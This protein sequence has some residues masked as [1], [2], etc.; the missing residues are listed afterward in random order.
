M[1]RLII[2]RIA[3]SAL[4]YLFVISSLTG[5]ALG[6]AIQKVTL[7]AA[8]T[9]KRVTASHDTFAQI[10]G[11]PKLREQAQNVNRPWLAGRSLPLA[12]EVTLPVALRSHVRTTL[13]FSDG[14]VALTSVAQRITKATGIP[15]YVHPEALLPNDLFTQRLGDDIGARAGLVPARQTVSLSG[16]SE[17]LARILDRVA[18]ALGVY[19]RYKH[20]RIEFYRTE[21]RVFNV[22]ALTLAVQAQAA[23][24]AGRQSGDSGFASSSRTELNSDAVGVME[25]VKARIEPFLTKAGIAVAQEGASALV[26]VTDTPEVLQQ[27]AGYLEKENRALTRR[28]RLIFEEITLMTTEA[29]EAGVDWNIVFSSARVAA[30]AAAPGAIAADMAQLGLGIRKGPFNGSEAIVSAL[31]KVGKVVRRSSVPV[32]TLNR[33]PVTHAVRTTFSYI[34]KVE[35][36]VTGNYL[37]AS[38]PTVSISQK[39]ETVG[40]LL[41]L[42]PDAQEDGQI[43]LSLAYDNTVAQPLKSVTFGDASNPLQ[44]QQVTID[45]NGTV[46]Q[47]ALQP[48]QPVLVSGFDRTQESAD[49]RRLNPGMPLILGGTDKASQQRLKTVIVITAQVEEGF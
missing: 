28:V 48:G 20:E 31:G 37:D 10:L 45:G 30:A 47:L 27:I 33:R 41:T 5:C 12:R 11:S 19:W 39:E 16:E 23:L 36:S 2:F 9:D 25:V 4:A 46:Q 14:P 34:D 8:E 29:V 32:L 6:D 42:V 21:T 44:L 40:S 26:V 3:C 15:V 35:S 43:L 22:R 24:G 17:S 38:L 7:S 18:A 1:S 13:L 49:L